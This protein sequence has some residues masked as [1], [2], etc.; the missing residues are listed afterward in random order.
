MYQSIISKKTNCN[1]KTKFKI[2][3]R[4]LIYNWTNVSLNKQKHYQPTKN[5][6]II[7]TCS[8]KLTLAIVYINQAFIK[9][10]DILHTNINCIFQEK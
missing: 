10:V 1:S 3:L 8:S 4:N 7:L 5:I 9:H 2:L 6:N